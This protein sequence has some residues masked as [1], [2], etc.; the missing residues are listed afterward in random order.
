MMHEFRGVFKISED[1]DWEEYCD[2]YDDETDDYKDAMES[3]CDQVRKAHGFHKAQFDGD[4]DGLW[5]NEELK[6][7]F[8]DEYDD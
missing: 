3:V 7:E 1:S 8:Y 4:H 2:Y 6:F 5:D